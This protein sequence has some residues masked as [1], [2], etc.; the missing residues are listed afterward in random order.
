MHG[1]I[2]TEIT[3]GNP[4]FGGVTSFMIPACVFQSQ[5]EIQQRYLA[6]HILENQNP[7]LGIGLVR[8]IKADQWKLITKKIPQMK[9]I[10]LYVCNHYL[11]PLLGYVAVMHSMNIVLQDGQEEMQKGC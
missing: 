2:I 7:I 6:V 10:V 11:C 3:E 4:R 5:V 8:V 1:K 9:L